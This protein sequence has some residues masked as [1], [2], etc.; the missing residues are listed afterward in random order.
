M[1]INIG[2][3]GLNYGSITAIKNAF[4]N[5]ENIKVSVLKAAGHTKENIK[6]IAEEIINNL[7]KNY[8]YKIVGFVISIKKWRKAKSVLL[9]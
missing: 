3:N 9:P 7:G 6:K 8:T 2:K 5:R 4:K 1:Q